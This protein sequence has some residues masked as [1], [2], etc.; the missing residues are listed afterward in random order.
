MC[1][2]AMPFLQYR[3]QRQI[4]RTRTDAR[5]RTTYRRPVRRAVTVAHRTADDLTTLEL[6]ARAAAC[7]VRS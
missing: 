7:P 4:A 1:E 2:H 3:L 5:V 6:T